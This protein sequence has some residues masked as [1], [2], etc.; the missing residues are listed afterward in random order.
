[1]SSLSGKACF[2]FFFPFG[3]TSGMWK[4]PGQGWDL[5]RSCR[6]SHCNGNAGS[7]THCASEELPGKLSDCENDGKIST[8]MNL[9]KRYENNPYLP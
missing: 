6:P 3:Y 9:H 5:S 7:L 2:F 8:E 4:S 1:M